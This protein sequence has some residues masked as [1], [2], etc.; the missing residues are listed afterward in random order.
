[1]VVHMVV[2]VLFEK[3]KRRPI[4]RVFPQ[5][6]SFIDITSNQNAIQQIRTRFRSFGHVRFSC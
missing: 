5:K 1:M 6:D 2:H 4:P 3:Y